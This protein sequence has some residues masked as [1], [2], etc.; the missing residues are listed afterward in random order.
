MHSEWCRSGTSGTPIPGEDPRDGSSR[1][2]HAL[3]YDIPD[4]TT[5]S[6]IEK[7]TAFKRRLL[8]QIRSSLL[9]RPMPALSDSRPSHPTR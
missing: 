6:D 8:N 4:G 7:R 5:L 9:V 3:D 1:I 2:A